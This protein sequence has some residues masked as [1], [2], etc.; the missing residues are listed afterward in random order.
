MICTVICRDLG[1]GY[2]ALEVTYYTCAVPK[3]KKQNKTLKFHVKKKKKLTESSGRGGLC[4]PDLY[5]VWPGKRGNRLSAMWLM[6][7]WLDTKLSLS[8]SL[9]GNKQCVLN[10]RLC[11]WVILEVMAISPTT[12]LCM[13]HGIVC[14]LCHCCPHKTNVMLG[15]D[16][17]LPTERSSPPSYTERSYVA[18]CQ[19][20]LETK[21][22]CDK[23]AFLLCY[24]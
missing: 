7:M 15:S 11:I 16:D 10:V 23:L 24:S 6:P 20:T 3:G 19:I 13:P 14:G 5:P 8:S 18:S 1:V 21:L 22:K 2:S 9:A 12:L 4:V 17:L